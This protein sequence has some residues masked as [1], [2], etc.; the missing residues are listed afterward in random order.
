VEG[1]AAVEAARQARERERFGR[2]PQRVDQW[3]RDDEGGA[4][5]LAALRC[6]QGASPPHAAPRWSCNTYDFLHIISCN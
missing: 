2:G 6:G 1:A 5:P 4:P 3:R